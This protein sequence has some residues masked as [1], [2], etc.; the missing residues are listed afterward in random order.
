V[1]QK[2]VASGAL[3]AQNAALAPAGVDEQAQGQR[4]IIFLQII[5]DGLCMA[6]FFQDEI[7]FGE[8]A[9]D[10]AM[11]VPPGGEHIDDF[12]FDGNIGR[13]LAFKGRGRQEQSG[14]SF[15]TRSLFTWVYS[16]QLDVQEAVLVC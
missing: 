9:N 4:Q 11:L 7:V 10:I 8:I 3:V 6:I 15:R 5:L 14:K 2:G 1:V 13:L 12:H 16:P